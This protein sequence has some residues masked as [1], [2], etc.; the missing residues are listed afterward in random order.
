MK[1]RTEPNKACTRRSFYKTTAVAKAVPRAE[2]APAPVAAAK[3]KMPVVEAKAKAVATDEKAKPVLNRWPRPVKNH[4]RFR[5]LR[6]HPKTAASATQQY[7]A[8]CDTLSQLAEGFYNSDVKWGKNIRSE[9]GY[10]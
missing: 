8:A 6:K 1:E 4:N 5:S 9:Q 2:P 3:V 7:T 10:V